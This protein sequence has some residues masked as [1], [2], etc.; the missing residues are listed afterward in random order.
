[1]QL[2]EFFDVYPTW[3]GGEKTKTEKLVGYKMKP[4]V[5]HKGQVFQEFEI[6]IVHYANLVKRLCNTK[7]GY[8]IEMQLNDATFILVLRKKPI[9]FCKETKER[10]R[11]SYIKEMPFDEHIGDMDPISDYYD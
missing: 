2:N 8:A 1:M 5:N 7:H 10:V 6:P 4:Y 9:G 11:V 3:N